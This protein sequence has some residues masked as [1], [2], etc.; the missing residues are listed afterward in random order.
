VSAAEQQ[1]SG[2]PVVDPLA[3]TPTRLF[4]A[5]MIRNVL[6]YVAHYGIRFIFPLVATPFL[7]HVLM[8][9]KFADFAIVNSCVWTSTVFMEFGFYLY[10]VSRTGA[11]GEDREALTAVVSEIS[12]AKL[13]LAP[14]AAAAY[15]GLSAWTGVLMR[16]PAA[17]VIGLVCALGYGASFAWY[18]QGRQRG[19]FAVANEAAPQMVQFALLLA[20]V[21][22]PRDLWLVF[23]L[24]AIPPL[25]SL[26]VA[27]HS[28][29]R[30]GLLRRATAS[31]LK[32]SLWE[33]SPYFFERICY[34]T[35]TSIM[36]SL[37]ALL[38]TKAAVADYSIGDR[39]GTLLGGLVAPLTQAAMPRVARAVSDADGGWRMS[40]LLAALVFGLTAVMAVAVAFVAGPVVHRFFS[41]DYGGAVP[42]ARIFCVT[43]CWSALGLAVANFILIPRNRAKVMFQSSTLAL[44]FGLAAQAALVP[45]WG[46]VGAAYGRMVSEATVAIVL[47]VAALRLRGSRDR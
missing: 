46:A 29:R 11:A 8:R 43:A 22:S 9:D 39:F 2:E 16:E 25:S 24:Q 21:R 31:E 27:L 40:T 15:V 6:L 36:P 7:A 26:G 14:V 30:E 47:L 1:Q 32:R 17:V 37:I 35:Y 38:A 23:A 13:L 20:L 19:F 5:V 41:A 3:A 12:C 33:A 28:I 18:V 45:R 44:V 10:G 42:V 34:S 4:D